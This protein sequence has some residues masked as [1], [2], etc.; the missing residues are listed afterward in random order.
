MSMDRILEAMG[1]LGA[2]LVQSVPTDDQIIMDHVRRAHALI[3]Q[4]WHDRQEGA[5]PHYH[6]AH[7][8][9]GRL[10]DACGL[11]GRDLRDEIHKRGNEHVH[12]VMRV[13]LEGIQPR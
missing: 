10:T 9:G 11:C 5:S 6:R 12:P 8:I 3:E 13:A 1:E 7:Y 4:E 2:A